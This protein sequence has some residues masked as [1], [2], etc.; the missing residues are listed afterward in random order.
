MSGTLRVPTMTRD[1]FFDWAEAQE[2]RWE[3]DGFQP[4]AMT[5]GNLNH[6]QI[7]FNI[8][9]ALRSRLG[10]TG[11]RPLG[12]DAGVATVGDSVRYPDAVV[13]CSAVN[14][15]SRL[16]PAPVVVFEVISP[17]SGHMDRI[18]KLREYA[19]VDSIRRYVIVESASI[20][21]TVHE[22]QA[23]GQ[24]WTVT[25][26]T[27]EDFLLLPEAGIEIPVAELYEGVDFPASDFGA[28]TG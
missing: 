18:V 10:G 26:A 20:G 2:R 9:V 14:G 12:M 15:V 11:C 27:V 19:V 23:A 3:F 25:P 28:V 8:H 6:K 5:G 7:A 24:R 21:L 4:V 16:V 22:R 13:T 17:T 1:Q